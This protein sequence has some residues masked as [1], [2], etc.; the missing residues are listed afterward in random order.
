MQ[1][2]RPPL[3]TRPQVIFL[4]LLVLFNSL[5]LRNKTFL[6]KPNQ[7][8]INHPQEKKH[9]LEIAAKLLEWSG[10]PFPQK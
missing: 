2:F 10:D 8:P 6:R 5:R 7:T 4:L 9:T 3:I 1:P